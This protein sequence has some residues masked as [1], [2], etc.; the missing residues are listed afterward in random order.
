M[1]SWGRK[2]LF[3][4]NKKNEIFFRTLNENVKAFVRIILA[5]PQILKRL[6]AIRDI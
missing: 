6:A 3:D 4:K 1:K 2:V 5:I